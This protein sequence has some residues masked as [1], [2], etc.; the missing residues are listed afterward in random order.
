M[1]GQT[2]GRAKTG[3]PADRQMDGRADGRTVERTEGR[4]GSREFRRTQAAC[5]AG[6]HTRIGDI[7]WAGGVPSQ[8]A[9][10]NR[11]GRRGR[12]ACPA[13]HPDFARLQC[14]FL[15]RAEQTP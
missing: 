5:P 6:W 15:S 4:L 11:A 12:A 9:H 3:E 14:L 2:D 13:R 1:D 8:A 10:K 7:G